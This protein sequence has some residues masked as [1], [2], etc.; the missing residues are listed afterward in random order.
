M[1]GAEKFQAANIRSD[2]FGIRTKV[3]A[4]GKRIKFEIVLEGRIALVKTRKKDCNLNITTLTKLDMSTGKLFPIS[5]RGLRTG[6][7]CRDFLDIVML[8]L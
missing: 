1:R 3:L 6:V 7:H 4:Q 2:Q 8:N 5:N